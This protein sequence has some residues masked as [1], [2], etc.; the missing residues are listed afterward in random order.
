MAPHRI[1][2]QYAVAATEAVRD[3]LKIED[4]IERHSDQILDDLQESAEK[5]PDDNKE[6]SEKVLPIIDSVIH[7]GSNRNDYIDALA[8]AKEL[9]WAKEMPAAPDGRLTLLTLVYIVRKALDES[10]EESIWKRIANMVEDL[11]Y[12][13]NVSGIS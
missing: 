2:D 1:I 13:E 7:V 9:E 5:T 11:R 10:R 12:D 3:R 4:F 8:W 6:L